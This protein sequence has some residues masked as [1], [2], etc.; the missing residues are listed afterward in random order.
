MTDRHTTRDAILTYLQVD[1]EPVALCRVVKYMK[2][3]HKV[4]YGAVRECLRRLCKA[5]VIAH[6]SRGMYQWGDRG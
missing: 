2:V 4:E 5:K 1:T 3:M 6:P